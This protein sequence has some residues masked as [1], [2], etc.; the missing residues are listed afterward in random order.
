ML[1]KDLGPFSHQID[2]SSVQAKVT[3]V[4]VGRSGQLDSDP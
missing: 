1:G 4:V 2:R 3:G